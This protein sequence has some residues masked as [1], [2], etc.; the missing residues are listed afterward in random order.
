MTYR[1]LTKYR[2]V[3]MAYA[4]I[5][6]IF[7]G[8]RMTM[9]TVFWTQV[10]T[11]GYG[12][13]DIF[14]FASGV[15]CYFSLAKNG[16]DALTFLKRRAVRI[17]PSYFIAVII[18]IAYRWIFD[19]IDVLSVIGNLLS[20]QQFT[21][22][23]NV[24]H[25][26]F[27]A[28]WLF[29]FAAPYLAGI[30]GKMK[31][32]YQEIGL[33]LF[34][35]VIA[36][37][38]LGVDDLRMIAARLPIFVLG[39]IWG[40]RGYEKRPIRKWEIFLWLFLMA[41]GIALLLYL[42]PFYGNL[43]WPFFM[44]VPGLCLTVSLMSKL[45]DMHKPTADVVEVFWIIG[46][47]SLEFGLVHLVAFELVYMQLMEAGYIA[48]KWKWWLFALFLILLFG[49]ALINTVENLRETFIIRGKEEN[50]KEMHP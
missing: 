2:S 1:D 25:W 10:Q 48:N 3:W 8:I 29:Y 44:I 31:K 11:F 37:P 45:L 4:I 35:W 46:S 23:G 49:Y 26:Y 12:G 34:V 22:R 9:K 14:F 30:V 40:K 6:V 19:P 39:M 17:L 47:N 38:F 41:A 13:A 24:F 42:Q 7:S 36:V 50:W 27:S 21:G 5:W 33:L 28:M 16:N 15:G 20:V 18:W 32:P 43:M